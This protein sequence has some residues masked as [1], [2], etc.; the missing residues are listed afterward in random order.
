MR[1]SN[2]HRS[3]SYRLTCHVNFNYVTSTISTLLKII[4]TNF[5]GLYTKCFVFKCSYLHGRNSNVYAFIQRFSDQ[6]LK[7]SDYEVFI[8]I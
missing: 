8:I 4:G 6:N 5:D 7:N 3:I 2:I 1:T